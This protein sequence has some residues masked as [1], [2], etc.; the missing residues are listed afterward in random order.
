MY[1]EKVIV[2]FHDSDRPMLKPLKKGFRH[3]VVV[4]PVDGGVFVIDP[5]STGISLADVKK[6]YAEIKARQYTHVDAKV[7]RNKMLLP[8]SFTCVD[9]VKRILGLNKPFILTPH[10]LYKYLMRQQEGQ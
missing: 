5:L 1:I 3:C 8:Y 2:V 6:P 9:V 7:V 10:Q 4:V